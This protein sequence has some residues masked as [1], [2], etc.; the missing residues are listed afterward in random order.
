MLIVSCIGELSMPPLST[1]FTVHTALPNALG[2]GV[3]V[4][5]PDSD[6]CGTAVNKAKDALL[7]QAS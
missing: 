7:V 1:S 3:N 4:R 5:L 2:A 6:S